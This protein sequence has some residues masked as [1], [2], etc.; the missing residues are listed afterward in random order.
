MGGWQ[1]GLGVDEITGCCVGTARTAD[2]AELAPGLARIFVLAGEVAHLHE[3][4]IH[5][6]RGN[7][8][9]AKLAEKRFD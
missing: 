9:N 4:D 5:E 6:H 8:P 3:V 1:S 7:Q 2:D